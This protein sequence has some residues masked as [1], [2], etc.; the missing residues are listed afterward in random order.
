MIKKH[1]SRNLTKKTLLKDKSIR[2]IITIKK[3]NTITKTYMRRLKNLCMF[4]YIKNKLILS[5][6]KRQKQLKKNT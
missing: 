6:A 5:V 4:Q 1:S 3:N 2:R